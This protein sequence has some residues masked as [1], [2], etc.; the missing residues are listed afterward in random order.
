M[1]LEIQAVFLEE[2]QKACDEMN[3]YQIKAWKETDRKALIGLGAEIYDVPNAERERWKAIVQPY[4]DK[5][6]AALGNL[7]VQIKK[8]MDEANS[9]HP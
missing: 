8:I 4:I 1:P 2:A 5:K 3:S 9:A 7:G 6:I